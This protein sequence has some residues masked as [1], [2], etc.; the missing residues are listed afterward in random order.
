M[1]SL[2]CGIEPRHANQ[3][4]ARGARSLAPAAAHVEHEGLATLDQHPQHLEA[5]L[6]I[7]SED[8]HELYRRAEGPKARFTLEVRHSNHEAIA[9]Y[10][11]DGFRIAGQRRHYYQDNGEDALIMWRT[12]A[13]LEGRLDDVPSAD[14]LAQRRR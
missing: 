1:R 9:L 8:L 2:A 10:E 13:T 14:P 12:L 3:H 6:E 5:A 7:L 4:R 11:R